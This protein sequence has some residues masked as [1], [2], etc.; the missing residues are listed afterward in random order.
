MPDEKRIPDEKARSILQRAAEIDRKAGDAISIDELRTAAR[1]AGIAE[2][3]FDTALAELSDE[4]LRA[5][6]AS[7][8]RRRLVTALAWFGGTVLVLLALT[9]LARM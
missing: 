5:R 7:T 2:S 8:G 4:Q 6:A 9:L 3:S 1:E